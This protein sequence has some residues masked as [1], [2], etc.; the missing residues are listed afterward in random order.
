M[1][2]DENARLLR[3]MKVLARK[4][5]EPSR[6]SMYMALLIA[7]L[8]VPTEVDPEHPDG[9]RF[10]QDEPLHG[11]SVYVAFTTL[12]DLKRW[13]PESISHTTM[14]GRELFPILAQT[15]WA[16][17]LST[18]LATSAVSFTSTKSRCCPRRSTS[19]M[20]GAPAAR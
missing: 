20:P 8:Y 7:T 6:K 12:S 5:D 13:R 17:A 11:R 18:R 14:Q 15:D 10:A 3:T 9:T 4:R 1:S 16:L 19:S 2:D